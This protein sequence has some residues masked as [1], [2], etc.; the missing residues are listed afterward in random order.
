MDLFDKNSMTPLEKGL[1]GYMYG[2]AFRNLR[3]Y[4]YIILY[5]IDEIEIIWDKYFE[6]IE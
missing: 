1:L 4:D 3:T 2:S 6:K 5:T